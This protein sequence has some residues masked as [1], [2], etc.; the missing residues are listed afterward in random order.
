[1]LLDNG[2]INTFGTFAIMSTYKHYYILESFSINVRGIL[3]PLDNDLCES[4]TLRIYD[5]WYRFN[6]RLPI[7][8]CCI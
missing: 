1:M 2:L 5:L 7:Y 3:M 8:P 4:E 6:G